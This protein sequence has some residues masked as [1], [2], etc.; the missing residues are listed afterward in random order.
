[1]KGVVLAGGKGSRLRPLT[2]TGAKQ[3]VPIANKPI[4]FY[5]LEHLVKAGVRDI[6]VIV[7]ETKDQVKTAVADGARFGARVTYLE[8]PAPLGI[9][10]AV[11]LAREFVGQD[12]FVVFLGDNF[13]LGGIDPFVEGFQSKAQHCQILLHEVPNP[14]DFGVVALRDSRI[15]SIQE[16]PRDPPSNLAIVGIYMFDPAVFEAIDHIRPSARNELEITDAIRYLIEHGYQVG[17]HVLTAPWIDTGKKDDIL[18][19]NRLVLQTLGPRNEGVMDSETKITGTVIVERN[20]RVTKSVL[21]GPC[22]IGENAVVRD[23]YIGPYTSIYHDCR[24]EGSEL[25]YCIVLEHS[26]ILNIPGRLA[27]SLIGRYVEVSRTTTR[28]AALKMVLGDHSNIGLM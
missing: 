18:H 7:G 12:K 11:G 17:Y 14:Q 16:K 8:Q 27:E 26:C 22:I 19:A 21:H 25:D 13:V 10:H 6:G 5:V 1:M 20:A 3:L 24:I 2:Y 15:V 4:L 23:S 9:A 28:P